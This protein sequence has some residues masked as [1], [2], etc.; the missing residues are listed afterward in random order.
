MQEFG[1]CI[2]LLPECNSKLYDIAKGF[3]PHISLSTKLDRFAAINKLLTIKKQ[4]VQIRILKEPII[5][6]ENGFNALQFN[7]KAIES[8]Q[9][10]PD[11]PHISFIYK[12]NKEISKE[13]ID[14]IVNKID[15]NTVYNFENY[16][17]MYC[18]GDYRNWLDLISI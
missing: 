7:V 1:Y 8:L 6:C 17:L 10:N 18:N 5:T 12:Y 9:L 13:E 14:E 4:K 2:W 11:D 3:N 15:F 16:K